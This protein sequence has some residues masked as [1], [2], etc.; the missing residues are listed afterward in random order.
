MAFQIAV[1]GLLKT[2]DHRSVVDG[3]NLKV[4]KGEI[5][6]LL[7]PNGAGKT[8]TL[9][10][11]EGLRKPDRGQCFICGYDLQK[12]LKKVRAKIGIQIQGT[13]FMESIQV[14][15]LI[16]L[17]RSFHETPLTVESL[18]NRFNLSDRYHTF[19]TDLSGGQK[20]RLAL[21]LALIN[22]PELIFLD[23]PTTGLDPQS[24]HSL[25]Q[26]IK[27]LKTR[28]RT[29]ILTTHYMDEAEQ[30]CDRL[31]VMD[32]GRILV[33]G[34]PSELIRSYGSESA[35]EFS[36]SNEINLADLSRL[37]QVTGIC[38][39]EKRVTLLCSNLTE[40]LLNLAQYAKDHRIELVDLRTRTGSLE[41]V[42]MKLTGR[43]LR[44]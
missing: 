20:Q 12:D 3:I 31:A 41:D 44:D 35:I 7:G 42:F 22:D 11:L 23:E 37:P 26:V 21:A 9:E 43:R 40:T 8:T 17:Y 14:G 28:S 38:E 13:R 6:G 5:F 19:V 2:Y 34:S 25:W 4:A 1:D 16:R 29:V 27:E 18:L 32:H 30:L 10:I 15:E 39:E 36:S 24:R 33:E